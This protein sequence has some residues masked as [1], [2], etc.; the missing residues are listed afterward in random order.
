MLWKLPID[1][2]CIKTADFHENEFDI[3]KSN[4]ICDNSELGVVKGM[5]IASLIGSLGQSESKSYR[6]YNIENTVV[7]TSGAPRGGLWGW[8]PPKKYFS[9]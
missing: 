3:L 8:S 1:L 5:V 4:T 7:G 2:S 9:T 6:T